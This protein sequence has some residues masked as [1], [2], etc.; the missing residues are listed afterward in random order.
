MTKV[1]SVAAQQKKN[2]VAPKSKE[3]AQ[4]MS[5]GA[6]FACNSDMSVSS[7]GSE[8]RATRPRRLGRRLVRRTDRRRGELQ[9][10]RSAMSESS[11][12]MT[13]GSFDCFD[14]PCEQSIDVEHSVL[15]S[16]PERTPRPSKEE[17][18]RH[19]HALYCNLKPRPGTSMHALVHYRDE[20]EEFMSLGDTSLADECA[21]EEAVDG[22]EPVRDTALQLAPYETPLRVKDRD[23]RVA[24]LDVLRRVLLDERAAAGAADAQQRAIVQRLHSVVV[25]RRDRA[26][27]LRALNRV[28]RYAGNAL[29]FMRGCLQCPVSEFVLQ[30]SARVPA[31]P[32]ARI[33]YWLCRTREASDAALLG[34]GFTA[35]FELVSR[36]GTE[37][38]VNPQHYEHVRARKRKK[39]P[40][41]ADALMRH[42]LAGA[43]DAKAD[44]VPR[45]DDVLAHVRAL[46]AQ[47]P[48]AVH[49]SGN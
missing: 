28:H 14:A 35:R 22:D 16:A 27:L 29:P 8:P 39:R 38:C 3:R 25:A 48:H 17:V 37:R 19:V 49:L 10:Q 1:A 11:E 34:R 47:M 24:A 2:R 26:R 23:G 6:H 31:Q 44:A 20:D 45:T 41:F 7:S 43:A 40:S 46:T 5:A 36:C 13:T 4:N 15:W 12:S 18:D 32:L 33:F 30:N 42:A 21:S 9:S